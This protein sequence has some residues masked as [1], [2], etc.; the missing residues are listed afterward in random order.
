VTIT[1]NNAPVGEWRFGSLTWKGDN[2]LVFSPIAVNGAP[3]DAPTEVA[4]SGAAG[5]TSIE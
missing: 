3:F 5:S 4:G 1:N 2:Y